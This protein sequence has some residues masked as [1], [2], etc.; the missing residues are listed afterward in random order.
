MLDFY[1]LLPYLLLYTGIKGTFLVLYAE[2]YLAIKQILILQ[3]VSYCKVVKK[4]FPHCYSG[5]KAQINTF[6]VHF[7]DIHQ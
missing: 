4:T 2:N 6:I 3:K 1:V 7:L 5:M